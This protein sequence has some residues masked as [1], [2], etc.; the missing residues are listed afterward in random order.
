MT[1]IIVA[2]PRLEDA[3][4][5]RNLLVRS[6]FAVQGVANNAAA[7]I[8][9]AN[10]LEDGIVV[11]SYKFS[12]MLYHELNSYLPRDFHMLLVASNQILNQCRGEDIM[13]L[14]MPL[15]AHELLQTLGMMVDHLEREKRKKK[16]KPRERSREEK[17]LLN[18]AKAVLMERN[19]LTEEEAHRY[20]QKNSMDT[21][22]SMVETAQMLLS[23]MT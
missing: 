1:S 11:C 7:V 14:S 12:D 16:Q 4:G 20:I 13:R 17:A 23:L 5:I 22:R 3:K 19:C 18:E 15:K 8:D 10:R 9:A 21:G 6:G 2:F